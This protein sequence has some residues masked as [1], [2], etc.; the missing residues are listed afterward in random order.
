MLFVNGASNAKGC[1]AGIVLI[2][3]KNEILEYALCF[4]FPN[5]NNGAK[6]KALLARM[7]LAEKLEVKNL[8][9]HNDSQFVVQQF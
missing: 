3:L 5:S 1:G 9:T 2:S 7:R 4:T 6:Y 8:T